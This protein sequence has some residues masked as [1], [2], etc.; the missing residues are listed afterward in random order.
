M[1]S[2]NKNSQ[3][4]HQKDYEVTITSKRDEK[5]GNVDKNEQESDIENMSKIISEC[6]RVSC[7]GSPIVVMVAVWQLPTLEAVC[8]QGTGEW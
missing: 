8:R 4:L 5:E 1:D 6:V 7:P 2:V 3:A